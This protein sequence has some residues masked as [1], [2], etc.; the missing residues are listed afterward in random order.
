MSIPEK[1]EQFLEH[2]IPYETETQDEAFL[3]HEAAETRSEA[4]E[5]VAKSV[6]V[7]I[8]GRLALV[9]VPATESVD[10]RGLRKWLG[11]ARVRLAEE[12]E[13]RHLFSDCEHG[14]MPIFGS[15]YGIPVLVAHEITDNEEISFFAGTTCD[16]V[17]V[18]TRDFLITEKPCVCA[19]E[20]ILS[21][22]S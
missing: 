22:V 19:R 17:R 21:K 12:S 14:A 6:I 1:L 15:A 8:D 2:R 9:V 11:A 13:V 7:N 4:Y 16:F 18:R 20:A 10:L 3:P 5:A